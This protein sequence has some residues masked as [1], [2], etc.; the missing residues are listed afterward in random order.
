MSSSNSMTFIILHKDKKLKIPENG[1]VE[2]SVDMNVIKEINPE[3]IKSMDILKGEEAAKY[4]SINKNGV[5]LVELKKGKFRK[6]P[7]KL[8]RK[9]Y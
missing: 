8:R 3:W 2:D 5:V 1:N 6:I 7:R 9:F 4:D